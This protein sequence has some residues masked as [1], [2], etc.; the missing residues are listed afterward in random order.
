MRQDPDILTIGEIRKYEAAQQAINASLTGH[1]VFSTLHTEKAEQAPKRLINL[2]PPGEMNDYQTSLS[3]TLIAV[4]AQKL[5][6]KN[7]PKCKERYDAREELA[8]ILDYKLDDLK[9]ELPE[10]VYMYRPYGRTPAG[11]PCKDCDGTGQKGR[12]VVPQFLIITKEISELI[13]SGV[14]QESLY[15][16]A[17]RK[18]GLLT[19]SELS[20]LTAMDGLASLNALKVVASPRIMRRERENLIYMIKSYDP[21]WRTCEHNPFIRA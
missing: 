9:K 19:F 12:I 8:A 11:D 14:K 4:Q 10:P 1:L 21:R 3:S 15:L 2:A 13:D 6:K 17:G 18:A 20:I 16:E 7:C 5:A